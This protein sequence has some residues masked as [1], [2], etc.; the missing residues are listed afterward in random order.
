M[1]T[2]TICTTIQA[3]Y[4]TAIRNYRRNASKAIQ[5]T[6]HLFKCDRT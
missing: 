3:E 2:V 4:Y 1:T 6:H 5:Q